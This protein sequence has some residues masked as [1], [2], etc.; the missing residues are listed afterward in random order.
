MLILIIDFRY[1]SIDIMI[2]LNCKCVLVGTY[3]N[4]SI[5]NKR[6]TSLTG[7]SMA[8]NTTNNRTSAALG[9]EA[10]DTEA[11]VDVRLR[12]TE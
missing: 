4:Q 10:D 8:L 5:A 6:E 12:K 1:F 2:A 9:T 11:A 7:A 3:T